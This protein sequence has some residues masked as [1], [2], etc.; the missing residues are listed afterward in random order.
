MTL[1]EIRARI[2]ALVWPDGMPKAVVYMPEDKP[3]EDSFFASVMGDHPREM[4]HA[5]MLC[6]VENTLSVQASLL[7]KGRTDLFRPIILHEA[8][9]P[10]YPNSDYGRVVELLLL[11]EWLT[12]QGVSL[13]TAPR[14]KYWQEIKA[15][16]AAARPLW[17]AL[18]EGEKSETRDLAAQLK[19]SR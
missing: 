4:L 7:T 2:Y 9:P 5:P 14:L 8:F 13:F 15:I 10:I 19:E 12:R 3:L 16:E 18:T 6:E 17:E 11:H 1:E